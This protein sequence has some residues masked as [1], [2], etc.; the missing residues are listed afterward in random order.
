MKDYLES[1]SLLLIAGGSA[2]LI[3]SPIAER[4]FPWRPR[5]GARKNNAKA[6]PAQSAESQP[7]EPHDATRKHRF[8]G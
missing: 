2:I 7:D 8:L 6:A 1:I 5:A 4:L 3:L